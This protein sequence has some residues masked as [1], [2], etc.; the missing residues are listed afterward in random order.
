MQARRWI[1][2]LAACALGASVHAQ[3]W[4]VSAD[5]SWCDRDDSRGD[6]EVRTTTLDGWSGTLDVDSGGNGGIAVSGDHPSGVEVTAKVRT[7]KS[8]DPGEVTIEVDGGTIRTDGPSGGDW[9]VSF[10]IAAP[11]R[12]DLELR[13]INGGIKIEGIEGRMRFSTRNG[14]I[15]LK[16]VA[17]DVKGSSMN[18]GVS[19]KLDDSSWYGEGLDVETKNGGVSL[20]IP[21]DFS[22]E[23]QIGTVN[24]TIHTDFPVKVQGRLTNRLDVRLG[25]G[26]AP[27][28]L[29]TTNGGVRIDKK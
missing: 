16:N 19:V 5:Q 3:S 4:E 14:G 29:M 23:L 7:W 2:T 8:V 9:A 28:R 6:C 17:G 15:A 1:L 18:G 12:T 10:R 26:G 11:S 27:V 13:A 22:A 25:G 24:G 20:T 21:E